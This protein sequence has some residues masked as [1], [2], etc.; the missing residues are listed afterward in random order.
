ML[1]GGTPATQLIE[2]PPA[3]LPSALRKYL[4]AP[5]WSAV[6][7]DMAWLEQP[8]NYLL[9]I[10]DSDY[11]PL[12]RELSNPPS[13]LF[14]HGDPDLLA[15][16]QMAIVGSRN[17]STS[18]QGN[19]TDFAA[20][21]ATSGLVVSSGL[22]TGIDAAAHRGALQAGGLTLAVAGTGPDRVYPAHNRSLAHDIAADGLLVTEFP[23][24]TPPLPGN[25][26][27]RNR[28]LAG[29]SLGVL[30]VEAALQSGSLITARQAADAGREVFALPGSI[31]N[32][33]ARGCHALIREGAKLVETGE[34]ILEEIAPLLRG[35]GLRPRT[36]T[37]AP[38]AERPA[39]D[40]A[41]Q[42]LLDA[43]GFDPVTTDQ[44]VE[45]TGMGAAEV[46]SILLLLE[47]Q[48]H[49]SSAMGGQ[50]TRLGNSLK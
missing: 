16:P 36:P 28:I 26:P 30:V 15:L 43:M 44:L 6:E 20:F 10:I 33:L 1:A 4:Q 37:S 42:K 2:R 8:D 14:L 29:L 11:P 13:A 41:H 49:V 3:D 35:A 50:F 5:D 46:S 40:P 22:A 24:G 21:L 45:L 32:P 25:F 12:L 48:G 23:T 47:L 38:Q 39:I 34:H 9:R 19:A 18:G 31:H 17:A 7:A 27:R